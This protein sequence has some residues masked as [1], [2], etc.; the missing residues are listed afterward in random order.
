MKSNRLAEKIASW[1][2]IASLMGFGSAVAQSR[3]LDSR[4]TEASGNHLF[5]LA[6]QSNMTDGL[7]AGFTKIA[8]Q[9]FTREKL[10]IAHQ[11]KPGRGIRFWDKDFRYPDNFPQPDPAKPDKQHG[12]NYPPLLETILNAAKG[13]SFDTVTLIWMQGESDGMRGLGD[14][15]EQSFLR[16][17]ERLKTDLN[18][19]EIN[20]VIG[21]IS[22]AHMN[23][24]GWIK[25]REVQMKLGEGHA[26]CGWIDTDDLNGGEAGK[27]GG[28]LHYPQEQIGILGERLANKALELIRKSH[29]VSEEN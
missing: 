10:T 3:Q 19:K 26:S 28:D 22:D 4:K 18:R 12:E 15:Y 2:T 17:L 1:A 13:Q 29:K 9:A 21:R 20:F 23:N 16:L 25:V 11:C 24:P 27:P 7:K 8:E 5:I 14:A 6:G